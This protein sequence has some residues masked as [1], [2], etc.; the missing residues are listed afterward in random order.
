MSL[1]R[2]NSNAVPNGLIDLTKKAAVS[3]DKHGLAGQRAAVYLV[4]DHSG[5]MEGFYRDGSVQR[6]AEQALG[7]SA[8]LDDDGTVPMVFFSSSVDRTVDVRLDN[9]AGIVDREHTK[10]YWGGTNY[11]PAMHHVADDHRRSGSTD[12]ALVIFQTDGAPGDQMATEQTLRDLSKE[13]LFFATVGFG[14][15]IQFLERL[16]DLTGR[17]VDNASFFHAANPRAVSD[18]ALYDGLTSEFAQWLTAAR[19][20]GIVR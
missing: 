19:A 18:E 13:P 16:D 11:A 17:A 20:A 12:P 4:L 8:N 7:L 9:Y 1:F 10:C 6:L 2:K 14:G 3:L 15:S 5:S